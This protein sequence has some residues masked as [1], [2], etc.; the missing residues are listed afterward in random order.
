MTTA[1]LILTTLLIGFGGG[2]LFTWL[3]I[4]LPWVLGSCAATAVAAQM[5]IPMK[6]PAPMRNAA[7]AIVGIMLGAGFD[8]EA[9]SHLVSWIPSILFMLAL[10]VAFFAIPF[11]VQ[12]RWS[13]MDWSTA[14]LAS[15]PGGLSVVT[16]L[17]EDYG[18]DT[19]RIAMAHTARIIVLLLMAPIMLGWV[20]DYDLGTITQDMMGDIR[21]G[22]PADLAILAACAAG[23]YLLG[24]RFAMPSAGLLFPL[25]LSAGLHATG[26]VEA[27]V[28]LPFSIFAQLVIGANIGLRFAGYKP[29]EI[30]HD[31]W[32]AA[33]ASLILAFLAFA[34]A[35]GYAHLTGQD[36]AP[37]LIAY[38]P[39]GAPELGVV[40]L[41]LGI[42][43]A[44]VAAHHVT[45]IM[46]IA[47]IMPV[48]LRQRSKDKGT[49]NS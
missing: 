34:A 2:V 12:R 44:L 35:W 7:I 29:R 26:L 46:V 31:T 48:V 1:R 17:A 36:V 10:S 9:L 3:T 37:L 30:V 18:A 40:A 33:S 24:K 15:V 6:L 21:W 5:K 47:A 43:P 13:T 20:A 11:L 23:G 38:Y 19:R 39:G 45:R 27:Q 49:T 32:L 8:E 41:T 4:P 14:F 28:P 16:A 42:N 25:L 22:S